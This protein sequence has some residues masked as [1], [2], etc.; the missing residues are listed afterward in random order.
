MIVAGINFA[1][2]FR[3]LKGN[4]KGYFRD[5]EVKFFFGLIGTAGIIFLLDL[6]INHDYTLFKALQ[7]GLFQIVSILTTTGYGTDDY[8][9]WSV[10]TQ[11]ILFLF[12]FLGG[13]AG[14]TGGGMKII[15]ALVVVKFALNE[16]KKLIHPNAVLPV[17]VNGKSVPPEIVTNI[18]GFFILFVGLFV[19]GS[20]IMSLLGMDFLSAIGSVAATIGNIGPGLGSVGPTD[21]YAHI[22]DFGKWFLSFLMLAGR[23]EIYTVIVLLTPVFWKK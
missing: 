11:L 8:E 3:A 18:S 9:M 6:F 16:L 21:N 7:K 14:S 22:S 2:H 1:I 12:M 20:I 13:C 23:L 15:R 4:M 5:S 17:R 19:I 10:T